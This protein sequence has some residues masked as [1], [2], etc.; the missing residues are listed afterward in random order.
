MIDKLDEDTILGICLEEVRSE[1]R[2]RRWESAWQLK[3]WENGLPV[4]ETGSTKGLN[5]K[6]LGVIT[7]RKKARVVAA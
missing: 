5:E 4:E 1:Q 7:I 2:P 3:I 6:N